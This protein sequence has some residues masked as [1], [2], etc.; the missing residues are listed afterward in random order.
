LFK[1]KK[2]EHADDPEDETFDDFSQE[3]ILDILTF[4]TT[5]DDK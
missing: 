5:L 2:R 3:E 1:N 4:V